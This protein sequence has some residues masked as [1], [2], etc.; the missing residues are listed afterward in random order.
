MR[1]LARRRA[2]IERP[3]RVRMRI[4]KPC[5]LA[6]LRLFGW[7]VRF[8]TTAPNPVEAEGR[9]SQGA[10][11]APKDDGTGLPQTPSTRPRVPTSA[12]VGHPTPQ[13]PA[14]PAGPRCDLRATPGDQ[15]DH[16]KREARPLC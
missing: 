14:K 8:T 16:C 9:Q 1:P 3:A 10:E 11:N 15:A 5:V 7:N 2:M 6:R 12:M 13:W 4:R